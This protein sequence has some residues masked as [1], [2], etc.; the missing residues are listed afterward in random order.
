MDTPGKG[1]HLKEINQT[2]VATSEDLRWGILRSSL[3][4]LSNPNDLLPY[5]MTAELPHK[6]RA[7]SV[8]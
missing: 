6:S 7:S 3:A 4:F 8:T 5:A 1:S 2:A